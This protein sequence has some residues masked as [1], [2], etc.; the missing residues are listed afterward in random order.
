MKSALLLAFLS[1]LAVNTLRP[2]PGPPAGT[3]SKAS[4]PQMLE[5]LVDDFRSDATAD[6]PFTFGILVSDADDPEWHVVIGAR[7][8]GQPEADVH[9]EI[10]FPEQPAPYFVTDAETLGAIYRGEMA[11]LTAMGKAFSTD[12]APLDFDL[13]DGCE[14]TEAMKARMVSLSFHFWTRGFPEVIRFGDGSR[15]RELHGAN[16][17]LFYYQPGFR[18]GWF[19]VDPGQHVNEDVN[20]RTN[21]FPTL[22]LCT[23]GTLRS[24]IDSVERDLE[25][26]EAALIGPGVSHEFFVT[27]EESAEGVLL[28]FGEGA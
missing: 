14:P 10:G 3:A 8:E 25:T 2:E 22:I 27:G 6:G 16:G 7:E 11:S 24:K 15:T 13:M 20:S 18:S 28:M 21:P 9:L 19:R 5:E 26:G 17:V 23:K 12:F 4:V 1:G